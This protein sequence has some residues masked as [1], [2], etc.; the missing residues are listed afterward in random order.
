MR[1][2]LLVASLAL[3][4]TAAGPVSETTGFA[5]ACSLAERALEIGDLD[6]AR[7]QIR[8]AQERD[9][10]SISAWALRVR[11]AEA[12]GDRDDL[13]F[14]LHRQYQLVVAQHRPRTERRELQARIETIDPVA[15]D[16]FALKEDFLER[17]Q[18]LAEKYEKDHRPHSAIRVHKEILA[19]DPENEESRAAIERIASAPDPSLAEDAK[20]KDLLAD[21]SEEWIREHDSE[22][23]DWDSRA[24]LERDNYF[25]YTDAGY[26]VLVR[27][28]EAMEQMNAFYRVFFQYGTEEDGR[29]VPRITLNIFKDRDEYLADGIGPPAKWSGGHFTGNAVETYIGPAGF[30]GMVSVL[31]HEASHQFVALA[32]S[33]VGWLNEG[34]ASFFEGCRILANGTVLM[35]LPANHR[36]FPLVERME[37]GW[38]TGPE[39]G[40]DPA[41]PTGA[42]PQKA[43][44]FRI[45]LENQYPWGPPW[46]APTWGVVFFLYN[47]QDPIDGRFVYRDALRVFID[48]SGG[49]VGEGAVRNF[50]EVVLGNPKRPTRGVDFS[51]EDAIELPETCEELDPVWKAWLIALRDEQS[52]RK[53]AHRPYLTWGRHAITRGDYYDA[54]EHYE[55]GILATP[56]DPEIH[57]AFADLLVERWKNEDRA[58]KLLLEAARL[59]ERQEEPDETAVRD[60]ERKIAKID[61]K[62]RNLIRVHERFLVVVDDLV[63]R[64]RAEGLDMM[65]MDLSWRMGN[66][67]KLPGMFD[68]FEE[69]ARR[70]KKSLAIWKLAYNE[71]N[72][73][74][75]SAGGAETF[76]PEN[77]RLAGSF[78]EYAADDFNYRFLTLDQITSGDFSMEVEIQAEHG[79]VN[80]AGLIFGQ[81]SATDFHSFLLYP[82]G[83]D[84]EGNEKSGF[85]DLVTFYG[86]A[87]YDT[88][89]HTQ[90]P[91]AKR[92][93]DDEN[94][95]EAERWYRLRID[96]TGLS[97]DAWLDGEYIATQEF[98]SLDVL[99]G[100][101]GLVVGTGEAHFRN[102]RYLA[103][104]ARDPGSLLE[105]EIRMQELA[106]PGES[107]NGSWLG[108]VPPFPEVSRWVQGERKGWEEAGPLPQ[109]LVLWSIA[110]NDLIDIDGWL[111][112]LDETYGEYG[113]RTLC[114]AEF[115]NAGELDAYLA[116][117]PMPGA[118]GLDTIGGELRIGKTFERYAIDRFNLPRL[119]L[120]DV[121]GKVVWEGDP[122]FKVGREWNADSSEESYLISPLN[123]LVARRRLKEFGAWRTAWERQGRTA[124]AEGRLEDAAALLLA[125]RDFE[126]NAGRF[127]REA[128]LR[129]SDL[130]GAIDAIGATADELAER[131]AEP[132][133]DLLLDWAKLIGESVNSRNTPELREHLKGNRHKEWQR[134]LGMLG[135]MR[136]RIEA[137]KEIGSIE[138]TLERMDTLKGTLPAILAEMLREAEGDEEALRRV[139]EEAKR[140]PARWLAREYFGW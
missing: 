95:S 81:K 108:Q 43:P 33:A 101:F 96:V 19:L 31:F 62:R 13:V 66:D 34:L 112:W 67:F 55:K 118:V 87:S 100:S 63:A 111:I 70:T 59:L 116:E 29:S 14:A 136:K 18:P 7:D 74:G 42:S 41:D 72:L 20:P 90:V 60:I 129:L 102:V 126:R 133:I 23:D 61:P 58:T 78:S 132:A 49:R 25:T 8:R 85:V 1:I 122:G 109:L 88:W 110:Q 10:R 3:V 26:E 53:E 121:D 71:E 76:I 83:T 89:R 128:R 98:S 79:E 32:T 39:D 91:P 51:G 28:A 93:E 36:L 127:V 9:A 94:R 65:V 30:E 12:T 2:P 15:V 46:Y 86:D 16:L 45:V 107:R 35:N 68:H 37:R 103:R 4:L 77:E 44:T 6:G 48:K 130:E 120:L 21:V 56:D 27:A 119:I 140:I 105:R 114:L 82:P 69:A 104:A 138:R 124:V 24:K 64:Y 123:D 11:W 73:D 139:V 92:G 22:H 54:M 84:A 135:P 117:H 75:W 115:T 80:F 40:I 137:E 57:V 106:P 134:A 38:M 50:E 113:L 99:R 17:L 47:Y 131:G 125:S 52:G 97:V 5:H